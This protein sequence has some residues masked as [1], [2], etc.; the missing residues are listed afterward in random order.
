DLCLKIKARSK[1]NDVVVTFE[2]NGQGIDLERHGSK[3]FGMYKTFH[4]HKDAKGI[5]LFITKNQ[6]EAMD[7]KIDIE[8]AVG[9]GTTFHLTFKKS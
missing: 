6:I 4:K 8:S 7:G 5:G 1:G 3:I 2:D 9:E